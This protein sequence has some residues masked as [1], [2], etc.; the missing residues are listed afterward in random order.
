MKKYL[1]AAVAAVSL[2]GLGGCATMDR[3][4]VGTVG[5]AVVGGVIGDAVLGTPGAIAGAIGG[6]Y[7]GNKAA[8]K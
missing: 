6:G 4:T 8:K 1:A 3:T 2:L 5:G 7:L